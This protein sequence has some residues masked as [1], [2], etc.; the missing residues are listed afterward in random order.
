M[1]S[2][3]SGSSSMSRYLR[4]GRSSMRK[5]GTMGESR[6]TEMDTTMSPHFLKQERS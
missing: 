4:V 2:A 6:E 1:A 3:E 5:G